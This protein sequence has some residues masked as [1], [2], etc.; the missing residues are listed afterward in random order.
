MKTYRDIWVD[1]NF[2]PFEEVQHRFGLLP[3]EASAW[4]A[5]LRVIGRTWRTLLR[6]NTP[7]ATHG[8]WY[9]FYARQDAVAPFS[10]V[11]MSLTFSPKSHQWRRQ[12]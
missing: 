6:G 4:R 7:L 11:K 3:A 9:G 2:L 8:N 12:Y 10:V 1:G 5:A